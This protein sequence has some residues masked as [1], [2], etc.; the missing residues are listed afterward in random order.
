MAREIKKIYAA[1]TADIVGS[2]NVH[3]FPKERDRKLKPLAK[4]HLAL[5]FIVSEYA[6]TAWD[7]FEGLARPDAIP[8]ILLDLRRYFY[9]F[10][11]WIGVGIGTVTE[12][13][14]KP[15]NVFAGGEAFERARQAIDEIKSGRNKSSRTTAFVSGNKDFDLV[16]NTI[17][18]LHDTLIQQI[19]SKQWQTI[20]AQ[21][22][23]QSQEKTAKKL[24]LHTSSV[25]RTLRR[26]FYNQI[27]ETRTTM[28]LLMKKYFANE[29]RRK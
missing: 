1:I 13:H 5:G 18:H 21:L 25:S 11:L 10:A 19:S 4:Q 6:V 15:I 16:A 24:G 27:E 9:P 14:R 20:N 22:S 28:G 3:N 12:P 8:G 17:Y 26:G 23:F 2:R 7:E 29:P